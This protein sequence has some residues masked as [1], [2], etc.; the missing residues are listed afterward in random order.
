MSRLSLSVRHII[1]QCSVK[2]MS[3]VKIAKHLQASLNQKISRQAV[4]EFLKRHS[5]TIQITD[6]RLQYKTKVNKLHKRVI[7]MWLSENSKMTAQQISRRLKDLFDLDISKKYVC[8]I[9]RG[10]GWTT[11]Q[12]KYCQLISHKNKAVRLDWC[13]N[14]L[15]KKETFQNVIFTDE[16]SVEIGSDGRRFFF[17]PTS[18]LQCQPA[19]RPKPKHHYKDNDS[20]HKSKSTKKWM[21]ENDILNNVMETPASSPDLNPIENLWS[22]LKYYLQ[23]VVKPKKKAELIAGIRKFWMDLSA[24][25]CGKYIDHIHRVIQYVVL[26]EGAPSRF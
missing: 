2:G 21:E 26:N 8:Q 5:L 17:K 23:T 13:L 7:N 19:K 22:T 1:L 14:A 24:T 6:Q 10:L 16:T 11:R 12:V 20:K 25:A 4:Y 9:R 15:D 3:T 18:A